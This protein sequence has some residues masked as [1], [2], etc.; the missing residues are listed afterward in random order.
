GPQ[1]PAGATGLQGPTGATGPQGPAG[2]TGPQGPTGP[3]GPGYVDEVKVIFVT[4]VVY[5]ADLSVVG[6]GTLGLWGADKLCDSLASAGKVPAGNYVALLSTSTTDAIDRLPDNTAGYVLSD[7]VTM[8][9][10]SKADLFD[11]TIA[12]VVNLDENGAVIST[13]GN[14]AYAWTATG[15]NGRFTGA[16]TCSDWTDASSTDHV[17][18][19]RT[20]RT[21]SQWL[22]GAA[23]PC[24]LTGGNALRL[25]CVQR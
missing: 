24:N 20:D 15:G 16:S 3:A 1:G 21:N 18:G 7:G 9:A 17:S 4:S 6:H 19:G 5:D 12:H 13:A 25:Y 10:T 2:A 14:G 11:G 23:G 22:A 8:V